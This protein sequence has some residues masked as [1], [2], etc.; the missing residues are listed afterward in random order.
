M[1]SYL[2]ETFRPLRS[3]GHAARTGL[4][5]RPAHRPVEITELSHGIEDLRVEPLRGVAHDERHPV[6]GEDVGV[7][8][9]RAVG[10]PRDQ[11]GLQRVAELVR[12]TDGPEQAIVMYVRVQILLMLP[13]SVHS[14]DTR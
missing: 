4:R 14:G 11:C 3:S 2:A 1:C 6:L 8:V 10:A 9:A 13:A 12:E 5:Q 7:E